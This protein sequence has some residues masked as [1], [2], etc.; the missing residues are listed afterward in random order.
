MELLRM[1]W[2]VRIFALSTACLFFFTCKSREEQPVLDVP[3]DVTKVVER[4]AFSSDS[5]FYFIYK[6]VEFGPRVPGSEAHEQ[7]AVW[8]ANVLEDFGAKVHTQTTQVTTAEGKSVPCYNII[9]SYL[10]EKKE[11]IL[12]AAHWDTRPWADQDNQHVDKPI[13]G[14]NDGASGVGVLLEIARQIQQN[15]TDIGIDIIF[16]DVEDSGLSHAENSYCLGSQYWGKN[17][18]QPNYYAY[19]AILLDMVG[20]EDAVFTMEGA[21]MQ[22]NPDLVNEVWNIA[23]QL[24]HQRYF[25]YKKTGPIID[26]HVYVYKYTRTPMIDIIH[27]DATTV[28]GFGKYWHTHQDN[29]N[30]ISKSTLQAVGETVLATI[31]NK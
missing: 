4:P 3:Q 24:G 31:R 17:P 26:D 15:G 14:A 23:H 6:Q 30:I 8:L 21:S 10:P 18:H 1:N 25:A 9:G 12:L 2:K 5:A 7:C 28:S 22:I 20:A 16:F 19:K 29:I 11:R 13:D 27:N